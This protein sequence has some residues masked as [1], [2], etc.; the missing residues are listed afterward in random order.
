[1]ITKYIDIMKK[2]GCKITPQRKSIL[3]TLNNG[4]HK[5]AED[6]LCEIKSKQPNLSFGTIY[7]NLNILKNLK[8][9]RELDFKDGCTRYELIKKPHHHFV[10]LK[11]GK[12]I[13]FD[14]CPLEKSIKKTAN[15]HNFKITDHSFKIYGLCSEC[16]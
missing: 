8:I 7:R 14:M 1:M 9:I 16:S 10:C 12:V 13:E 3:E 15:N 11:C 2:R 4:G 6:I 5:S